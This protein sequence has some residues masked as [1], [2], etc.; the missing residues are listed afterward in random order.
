MHD[1]R[2]V[3]ECVISGDIG[4]D[5]EEERRSILLGGSRALD[6]G[7]GPPPSDERSYL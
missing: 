2:D 6:F 4:D 1:V 7:N 3:V 5:Y